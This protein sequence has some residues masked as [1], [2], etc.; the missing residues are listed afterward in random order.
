MIPVD[1]EGPR[2]FA[3]AALEDGVTTTRRLIRPDHSGLPLSARQ[4]RRDPADRG[5]HD[6]KGLL[7]SCELD[8]N[9]YPKAIKVPDAEMSALNI[10]RWGGRGAIQSDAMTLR[11]FVIPQVRRDLRHARA[12][13]FT[14][15]GPVRRRPKTI[16]SCL[17]S[18]VK[19]CNSI[20]DGT[21]HELC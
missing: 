9:T 21:R 19:F 12:I 5:N 1:S 18:A 20:L 10:I 11:I 2:W 16:A 3:P 14:D 13:A 15:T 4:L 6:E 7:V 8:R 17:G